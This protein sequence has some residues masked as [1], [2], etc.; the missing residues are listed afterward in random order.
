MI[1]FEHNFE[2]IL[3]SNV[4]EIFLLQPRLLNLQNKMRIIPVNPDSIQSF[5]TT[6]CSTPNFLIPKFKSKLIW[7]KR[8]TPKNMALETYY[9]DKLI[10]YVS[11]I[12]WVFYASAC[13]E[14]R[15]PGISGVKGTAVEEDRKSVV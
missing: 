12:W 1:N 14:Q 2:K 10:K 7:K 15:F 6:I 4:R 5:P 9:I 11:I 3:K 8:F 13:D